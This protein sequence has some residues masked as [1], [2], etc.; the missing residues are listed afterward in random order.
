MPNGSAALTMSVEGRTPSKCVP[1]GISE[2]GRSVQPYLGAAAA[3]FMSFPPGLRQV[4]SVIAI[5]V[6]PPP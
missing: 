1:L 6:K 3:S 5:Q 4:G 2:Y